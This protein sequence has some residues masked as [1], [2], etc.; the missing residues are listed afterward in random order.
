[1]HQGGDRRAGEVVKDE[2]PMWRAVAG[3]DVNGDGLSFQLV[4]KVSVA[5]VFQFSVESGRRSTKR[6]YKIQ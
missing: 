1:M 5:F 4:G 6:Y 3:E 2:E